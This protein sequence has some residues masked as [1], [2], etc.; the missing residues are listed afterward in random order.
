M[1]SGLLLLFVGLAVVC[2]PI[3]VWL[4]VAAVRESRLRNTPL[5]EQE[6]RTLLD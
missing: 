4:V 5:T 2:L 3:G 6:T 1:T